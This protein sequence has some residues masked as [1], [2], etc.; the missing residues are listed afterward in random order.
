MSI[1]AGDIV[2]IWGFDTGYQA[3]PDEVRISFAPDGSGSINPH[4]DR[5]EIEW[6]LEGDG[7]LSLFYGGSWTGPFRISIAEH[8]LPLGRFES[9]VSSSPLLP[10]GLGQFQRMSHLPA[11]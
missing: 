11:S 7:R 8:D 10:F 5:I 1:A 3:N 4:A 9:L 2:G 6:R